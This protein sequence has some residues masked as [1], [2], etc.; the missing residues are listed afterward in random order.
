MAK[1]VN[2]ITGCLL[3]TTSVGKADVKCTKSTVL[4]RLAQECLNAVR[5]PVGS[6]ATQSK[7]SAAAKDRPKQCVICIVPL[8]PLQQPS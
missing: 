8:A 2:Q 5:S 6:L 7:V 1:M 4:I 3:N